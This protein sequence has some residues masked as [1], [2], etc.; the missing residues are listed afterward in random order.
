MPDGRHL[1]RNRSAPSALAEGRRSFVVASMEG[2]ITNQHGYGVYVG[3][4][5]NGVNVILLRVLVNPE[6]FTLGE[7]D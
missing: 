7:P 2:W 5:V 1:Y 3:N 4:E 6:E